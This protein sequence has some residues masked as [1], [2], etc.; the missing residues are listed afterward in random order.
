MKHFNVKENEKEAFEKMKGTFH[1]KNAMAAPKMQKVVVNVGTG[2]AVKKDKIK[3]DAISDRLAKIT[4]QKGALRGAH[5]CPD[6][7]RGGRGN[8]RHHAWRKNVRI[9]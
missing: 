9:S 5:Q 1:F 4:G 6:P 8:R 3:N 2:T 7:D